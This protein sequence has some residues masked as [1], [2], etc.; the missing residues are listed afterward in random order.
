[1]KHVIIDEMQDYSPIQYAVINK[2]FH[3]K[4]TILGDFG[5]MINP[6]S[7]NLGDSISTIFTKM[8]FVEL[9]KKL[10]ILL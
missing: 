10:S 5:Q 2:L 6:F 9:K 8:E 1:M 4:K 7:L 3:C